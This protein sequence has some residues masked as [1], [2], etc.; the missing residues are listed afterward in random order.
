MV[1]AVHKRVPLVTL[2]QVNSEIF[3]MIENTVTSR[4]ELVYLLEV[5]SPGRSYAGGTIRKGHLSH[6][7]GMKE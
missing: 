3:M 2:Y 7:S 6:A 5:R 4:F 1:I